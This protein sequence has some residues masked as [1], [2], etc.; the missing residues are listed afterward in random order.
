MQIDLVILSKRG[1]NASLGVFGARLVDF[2]LGQDQNARIACQ[3]NRGAQPGDAGAENQEI[4]TLVF[5]AH[6]D[7]HHHTRH[8]AGP[9]LR[10][11]PRAPG[12]LVRI[13]A[14]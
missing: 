5:L 9:Q 14:L 6:R 11:K 4:N 8:S 2:S 3:L 10:V 7:H 1:G 12:K 13:V